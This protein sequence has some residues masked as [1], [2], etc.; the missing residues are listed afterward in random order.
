MHVLLVPGTTGSSQ[1][2]I[3]TGD[4][5][6]I[7]LMSMGGSHL[8]VLLPGTMRGA[9]ITVPVLVATTFLPGVFPWLVWRR[10]TSSPVTATTLLS[11]I[12]DGISNIVFYFDT[13]VPCDERIVTVPWASF[14]SLPCMTAIILPAYPP[15]DMAAAP[16]R[17]WTKSPPILLALLR[18]LSRLPLARCFPPYR[19]SPP[20]LGNDPIPLCADG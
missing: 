4:I 10:L 16:W 14:I 11:R 20:V 5:A 8:F 17:R 3:F 18:L 13:P 15:H 2:T 9:L 19:N 12:E 6:V 7:S 1:D